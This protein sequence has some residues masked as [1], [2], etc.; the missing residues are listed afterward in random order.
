MAAVGKTTSG[1]GKGLFGW[2]IRYV[3]W[4]ALTT[5]VT[6]GGALV[7]MTFK[8]W[9]L[10]SLVTSMLAWPVLGLAMLVAIPI[11]FLR[12][13]RFYLYTAIGGGLLYNLIL[14]MA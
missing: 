11:A 3:G 4:L 5:L 2:F 10:K 8:D 9:T 7:L 12:V 1:A 14:L 6:L 13:G